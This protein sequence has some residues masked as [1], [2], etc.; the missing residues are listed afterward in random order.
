MMASVAFAEKHGA[1]RVRIGDRSR[2]MTGGDGANP[3]IHSW[4]VET[5]NC[6]RR[7]TGTKNLGTLVG[8]DST[9]APFHEAYATTM[10]ECKSIRGRELFDGHRGH[11]RM[12]ALGR[13]GS[14]IPL[15]RH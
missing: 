12:S 5:G 14:F 15:R 2:L 3:K 10:I 7:S 11:R 4:D 9:A 8:S 13:A 6:I 1:R